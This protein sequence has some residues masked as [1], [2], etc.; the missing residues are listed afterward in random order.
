MDH[1][2]SPSTGGFFNEVVHGPRQI[3]EPQTEKQIKA[4]RKPVYRANP[5]CTIP[6]DAVAID[7]AAWARLLASQGEGKTIV[8]EHGRPVAIERAPSAEEQLASIRARRD[9][10]LAATDAMVGVPDYPITADQREQLIEWRAALRDFPDLVARDLPAQHI[11]WPPRPSW[12][13]EN[14]E[15]L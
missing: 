7:Q 13:G 8:V 4:G 12:L 9:R 2:F 14:G 3:A 11:A 10:M 6:A 15:K 1:F 5:D